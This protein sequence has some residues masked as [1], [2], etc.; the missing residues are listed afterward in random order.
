LFAEDGRLHLARQRKQA[1]AKP[2]GL[3]AT[4]AQ[5]IGNTLAKIAIRTGLDGPPK[6]ITK[7]KRPS[8]TKKGPPRAA[9]AVSKKAASAPT[10]RVRPEI[11]TRVSPKAKKKS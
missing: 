9:R 10:T 8:I 3:M 11:K 4:T 1:I 7:R 2:E 6:A 5:L